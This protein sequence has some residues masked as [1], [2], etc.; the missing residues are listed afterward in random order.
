MMTTED[1]ITV[2]LAR[3]GY[4]VKH[5]RLQSSGSYTAYVLESRP[6]DPT[7]RLEKY[8]LVYGGGGWDA[9]NGYFLTVRLVEATGAAG[10]E[11]A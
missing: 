6:I 3:A 10:H 2:R 8:G 1:E 11:S 9:R 4:T 7:A 5:V